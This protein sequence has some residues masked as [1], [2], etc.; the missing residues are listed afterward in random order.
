MI[1]GTNPNI[2][3]DFFNTM[4]QTYGLHLFF[5]F[6]LLSNFFHKFLFKKCVGGACEMAQFLQA[7]AVHP[8]GPSLIHRIHMEELET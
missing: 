2:R 3:L 7:L 6:L 8:K 4:V 5:F 1:K